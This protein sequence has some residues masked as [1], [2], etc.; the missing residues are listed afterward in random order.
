MVLDSTAPVTI[1]NEAI[2]LS[3]QTPEEQRVARVVSSEDGNPIVSVTVFGGADA[4]LYRYDLPQ[5]SDGPFTIYTTAAY[6]QYIN[7]LPEASR[8]TVTTQVRIEAADARGKTGQYVI[9]MVASDPSIQPEAS[10][11]RPANTPTQTANPGPIEIVA[12]RFA[13]LADPSI[14]ALYFEI[15]ESALEQI[16][17]CGPNPEYFAAELSRL[18]T[19]HASDLGTEFTPV[20]IQRLCQ[21]WQQSIADANTQRQDLEIEQTQQAGRYIAQRATATTS[22]M[23]AGGAFALFLALIFPLSHLAMEE[24]LRAIR[25]Q[26]KS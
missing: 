13:E 21:S 16:N 18:L 25:E 19:P 4:E 12:Q 24:H 20:L 15:Y 1:F 10:D 22:L 11:Q 6:W 5:E 7:E 8:A 26:Q 14:S 9:R 17:N 23:I 2:D 3:N